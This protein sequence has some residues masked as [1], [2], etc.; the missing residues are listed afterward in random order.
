MPLPLNEIARGEPGA[1][2]VIEMLPLTLPEAVGEN[3]A[4]NVVFWPAFKVIGVVRPEMLKVGPD[5]LSEE[6]VTEAVPEFESVIGTVPL[7]PTSRAPKLTLTG[8]DESAPWVPVPVSATVGSE[9]LLVTE[10][11]PEAFPAA[12]G[13]NTAEKVALCPA[14]NV[15]GTVIPL[16]LNPVPLALT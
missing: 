9:A 3:L 4:L 11:E 12:V 6:I 7:L 14:F 2:L 8:F 1:L 10:M 5:T 13:S 16:T 15:M